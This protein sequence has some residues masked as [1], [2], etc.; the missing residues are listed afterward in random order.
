[1]LRAASGPAPGGGSDADG[2]E[3]GA[4]T[5]GPRPARRAWSSPA[6]SSGTKLVSADTTTSRRAVAEQEV[7]RPRRSIAS[8]TLV[9]AGEDRS[10]PGAA[11]SADAGVRSR[12]CPA[13]RA[14]SITATAPFR[15]ATVKRHGGGAMPRLWSIDT[16]S[17]KRDSLSPAPPGE[18]RR[19]EPC[20]GCGP[21]TRAGRRRTGARRPGACVSSCHRSGSN[22]VRP[23]ASPGTSSVEPAEEQG[24]DEHDAPAGN[25]GPAEVHLARGDRER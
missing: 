5:R 21:G 15:G 7:A 22:A 20:R 23:A 25:R 16:R 9:V 19:A 18:V 11:A 3:P 2:C 10:R 4:S 6:W 24:A 8:S 13:E 17:L 14:C 1:M 12:T